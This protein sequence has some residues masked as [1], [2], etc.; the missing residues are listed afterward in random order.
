MR[1]RVI[2]SSIAV[3][4]IWLTWFDDCPMGPGFLPDSANFQKRLVPGYRLAQDLSR[5]PDQGRVLIEGLS[6]TKAADQLQVARSTA[7][8]WRHRFLRLPPACQGRA[9]RGHRRS[10]QDRLAQVLRERQ[11]HKRRRKERPARRGGGADRLAAQGP[12]A[13]RL[14]VK[15]TAE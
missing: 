1:H 7:F 13:Q 14:L 12:G 4:R 11:R 3:A 5:W 9:L 15:P 2:K 8:R 10:R 6:M